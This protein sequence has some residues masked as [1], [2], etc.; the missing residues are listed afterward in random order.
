MAGIDPERILNFMTREELLSWAES[1]RD[2]V[3]RSIK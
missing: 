3:R 1:V 2:N